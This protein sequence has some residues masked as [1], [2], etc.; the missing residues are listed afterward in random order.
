[1]YNYCLF[2]L[3]KRIGGGVGVGTV[4]C[5]ISTLKAWGCSYSSTKL[6]TSEQGAFPRHPQRQTAPSPQKLTALQVPSCRVS[7][8]QPSPPSPAAR[9]PPEELVPFP[10]VDRNSCLATHRTGCF[11]LSGRIY[12]NPGTY[13][14]AKPGAC[15]LLSLLFRN[16]ETRILA[17]IL[18]VGLGGGGS[19]DN[20]MSDY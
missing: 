14:Q 5:V 8:N 20:G 1:M 15:F 11:P 19:Y 17:W 13:F 16:T 18:C 12:L 4:V 2:S 7:K 6:G 10:M 9:R 3:L